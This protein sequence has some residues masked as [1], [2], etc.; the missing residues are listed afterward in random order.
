MEG[1]AYMESW[2]GYSHLILITIR[3]YVS[4]VNGLAK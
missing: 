3:I 4:I 2:M 1:N